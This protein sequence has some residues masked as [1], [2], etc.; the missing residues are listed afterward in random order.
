VGAG[1]ILLL[2][3]IGELI[4]R[5]S[6]GFAGRPAYLAL[7]RNAL[8]A[9]AWLLAFVFCGV[10]LLPLES[11]P[12]RVV[13]WLVIGSLVFSVGLIASIVIRA[14]GLQ[15]A[16][17]AAQDSTPDRFW[18]AG[19]FYYNPGDP[20]LMV[21]KRFGIGYTLNFAHPVAWILLGGLLILPPALPLLFHFS[22]KK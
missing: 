6:A 7:T 11:S 21:P 4:P 17:A 1:L 14:R 8:R 10:G 5:T 15:D 9:V 18:K 3:L 22:G 2:A 13:P 19:L 20:A 12:D 16:M